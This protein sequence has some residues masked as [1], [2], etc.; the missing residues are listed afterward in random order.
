MMFWQGV[1]CYSDRSGEVGVFGLW[2]CFCLYQLA[3]CFFFS[4]VVVGIYLVKSMMFN[5]VHA[6]VV[7]LGGGLCRSRL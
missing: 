2:G 3:F 6:N 7:G 1:R 4:N 5:C